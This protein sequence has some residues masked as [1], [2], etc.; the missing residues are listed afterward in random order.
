MGWPP[1]SHW[2]VCTTPVWSHV[3]AVLVSVTP[4]FGVPWMVGGLDVVAAEPSTAVIALLSDV[5][6]SRPGS[7]LVARSVIEALR[8]PGATV[9]VAEVAPEIAVPLRI[10]CRSVVVSAG[11]QTGA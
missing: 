10:H 2:I 11:S 9:Y 5:V 3:G 8:S 1:R 7:V 4:T 6:G